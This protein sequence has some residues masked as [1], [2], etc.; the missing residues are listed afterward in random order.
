MFSNILNIKQCWVLPFFLK[1]ANRLENSYFKEGSIKSLFFSEIGQ[2]LKQQFLNE[3]FVVL[4]I[5][6]RCI[7]TV[8][9]S[10]S[11]EI[12]PRNVTLETSGFR[13]RSFLKFRKPQ[14]LDSL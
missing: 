5:K 10:I 11:V 3:K 8:D 12:S 14:S 4:S 6:E 1:P 13:V 7:S 2:I 9:L